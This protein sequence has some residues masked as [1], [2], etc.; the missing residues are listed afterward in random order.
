MNSELRSRNAWRMASIVRV[1]GGAVEHECQR[2]SVEPLH[3]LREHVVDELQ[4][5]GAIN[6]THL[7]TSS[8]SLRHRADSYMIK[9]QRSRTEGMYE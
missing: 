5:H 1:N 8:W 2:V 6:A 9:K 4:Q 7:G 3:C